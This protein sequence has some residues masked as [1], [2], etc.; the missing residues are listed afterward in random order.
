M[1]RSSNFIP[2]AGKAIAHFLGPPIL[3]TIKS[4]ACSSM[5]PP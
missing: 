5:F 1:L 2:L 3:L 4:L